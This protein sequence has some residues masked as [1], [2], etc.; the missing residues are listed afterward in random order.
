MNCIPHGAVIF[1]SLPLAFR[2][3]AYLVLAIKLLSAFVGIWPVLPLHIDPAYWV[4]VAV[5]CHL[6]CGLLFPEC[7]FYSL[8][9]IACVLASAPDTSGFFDVRKHVPTRALPRM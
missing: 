8:H 7:S 6:P 2:R 4:F 5:I 1:A 9:C 3:V